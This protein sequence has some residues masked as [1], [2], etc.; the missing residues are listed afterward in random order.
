M[1]SSLYDFTRVSYD[2]TRVSYIRFIHI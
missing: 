1:V 2:F